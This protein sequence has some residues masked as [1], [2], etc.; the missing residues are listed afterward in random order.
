MALASLRLSIGPTTGKD[1]DGEPSFDRMT[2]FD[3]GVLR[4]SMPTDPF[5][6]PWLTI[7]VYDERFFGDPVVASVELPLFARYSATSLWRA[8]L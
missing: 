1:N 3:T 7:R 2:F 5:F 8:P 6:S 4:V